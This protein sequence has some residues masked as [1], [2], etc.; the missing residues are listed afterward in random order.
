MFAGDP[1][2]VPRIVKSTRQLFER[3][4]IAFKDAQALGF[5]GIVGLLDVLQRVTTNVA[6]NALQARLYRSG[7]CRSP[8]SILALH[9]RR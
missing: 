7:A 6:T 2:L 5:A 8:Q 9:P 3:R 1:R 4:A